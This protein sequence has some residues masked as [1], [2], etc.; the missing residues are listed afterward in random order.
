[1][2]TSQDICK[3]QLF[4]SNYSPEDFPQNF[5][6][7]SNGVHTLFIKKLRGCYGVCGLGTNLHVLDHQQ[8]CDIYYKVDTLLKAKHLFEQ[9][10]NLLI[11][12][13]YSENKLQEELF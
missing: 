4:K 10:I 5:F 7:Y 8:D 1:M 11:G 2:I 13:F 6:F 9:T 12:D 3:N